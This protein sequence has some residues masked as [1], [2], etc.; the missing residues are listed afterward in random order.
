MCAGGKVAL[1][2]GTQR[3][4]KPGREG[5]GFLFGPTLR[6]IHDQFEDR[7]RIRILIVSEQIESLFRNPEA[8]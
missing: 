5:V 3:R 8:A 2:A 1:H 6:P 7:R 4:T